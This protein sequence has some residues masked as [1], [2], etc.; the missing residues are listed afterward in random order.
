MNL[1]LPG[2]TRWASLEALPLSKGLKYVA[3]SP[4]CL[5]A[6]KGVRRS[7]RTG[8]WVT[9]KVVSASPAPISQEGGMSTGVMAWARGAWR[10][11]G[12]WG[13]FS[14]GSEQRCVDGAGELNCCLKV[15]WAAPWQSW[16]VIL[17]KRPPGGCLFVDVLSGFCSSLELVLVL[18]KHWMG[19]LM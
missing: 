2:G 12:T 13:F 5:K 8:S 16:G 1:D 17:L 15:G 10:K 9:S 14:P 3:C 7:Q 18:L 19:W 11:T 6:T 4:S